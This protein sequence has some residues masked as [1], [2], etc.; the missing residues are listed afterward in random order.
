MKSLVANNTPAVFNKKDNL[1]NVLYNALVITLR[2][3]WSNIDAGGADL[4][5]G[6]YMGFGQYCLHAFLATWILVIDL[7]LE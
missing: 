5:V 7:Q 2:L 6:I 3:Y 1:F 4:E